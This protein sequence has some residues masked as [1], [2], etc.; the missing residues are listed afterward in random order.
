MAVVMSIVNAIY[1]GGAA[2]CFTSRPIA[3]FLVTVSAFLFGCASY[4]ALVIKKVPPKRQLSW[5]KAYSA[6]IPIKRWE[7]QEVKP[8]NPPADES[9]AEPRNAAD[10]AASR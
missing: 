6:L 8:P 2:W 5:W 3:T 9:T 1:I 10:S 4:I 7:L